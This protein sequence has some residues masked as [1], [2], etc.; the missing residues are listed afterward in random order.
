MNA[1][2]GMARIWAP[3]AAF[4]SATAG[5][6]LSALVADGVWDVLSWPA[7]ACW[8]GPRVQVIRTVR[9]ATGRITGCCSLGAA[10]G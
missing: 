6:L 4:G 3:P 7:L 9:Q 8:G 10:R 2:L 1:R 5:G